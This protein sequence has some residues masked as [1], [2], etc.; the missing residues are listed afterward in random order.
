M[1][2]VPSSGLISFSDLNLAKGVGAG[3]SRRL[4]SMYGFAPGVPTSGVIKMS[5]LR[6]KS[7]PPPDQDI[8]VYNTAS[9]TWT[10]PTG[11]YNICVVCVGKGGNGGLGNTLGGGGGGGG[12]LIYINNFAVVP[13]TTFSV[14]PGTFTRNSG[15]YVNLTGGA[16]GNGVS[17][18]TT[19]GAQGTPSSSGVTG[20]IGYSGGPGGNGGP[21]SSDSGGGGGAGGFTGAG[22]RGGGYGYGTYG[23]TG[24]G[25]GGKG[26]EMSMQSPYG[27]AEGV[28]LYG[29]SGSR[30]SYGAGAIG[31]SA[32]SGTPPQGGSGITRIMCTTTRT[33]PYN[34]PMASDRV[35][36]SQ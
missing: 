17:Y 20:A 11:V 3:N 18:T 15:S 5:D 6:G 32:Q 31:T 12:G 19:G 25:D 9:Y 2:V 16:G 33:F 30:T 27:S 1:Y 24:T 34:C 29:L 10:V 22:G 28:F 7:L 35:I 21:Y 26:G 13:G 4:T 8:E 23:W 14:T 36:I